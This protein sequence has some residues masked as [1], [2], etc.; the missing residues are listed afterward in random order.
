MKLIVGL[1]NPGREYVHSRHNVGFDVVDIL[2]ERWRVPLNRRK[3]HGV[4]GEGWFGEDRVM[5]LEPQ[6]FMN[7]SGVSV[8]EAV[9]FYRVA[10]MDMM[11][12]LD[13][14]A[15]PLGQLR[16]RADGSAG[17]HNGLADIID[18]LGHVEF[19][20]MRIG[21]GAARPG[22]AVD[23]VLGKFS[24]ED[25]RRLESSYHRA[26]EAVE[27]WLTEGISKAMSRYNGLPTE[28]GSENEDINKEP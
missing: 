23:H 9:T 13:D 8:A 22:G 15:L 26:A 10:N 25:R 17:G 19:S 7:R 1:G 3:H 21:I 6:T 16:L 28:G 27:C 14:M 4:V 12:I 18:R 11:V 5:L 20:R 24:A 2:A